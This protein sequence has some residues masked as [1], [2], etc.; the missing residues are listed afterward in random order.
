MMKVVVLADERK[1][2]GKEGQREVC[3]RGKNNGGVKTAL[4]TKGRHYC[5]PSTSGEVKGC[6]VIVR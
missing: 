1:F 4:E 5:R 6:V 2:A 3:S